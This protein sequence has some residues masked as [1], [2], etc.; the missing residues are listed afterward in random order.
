MK[1]YVSKE[2][3]KVTTI[4]YNMKWLLRFVYF[5]ALNLTKFG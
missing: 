3:K 2:T 4:A 5:H 1:K